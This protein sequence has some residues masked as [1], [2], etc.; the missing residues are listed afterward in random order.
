MSIY[1]LLACND[2]FTGERDDTIE[3]IQ[4]WHEGSES[5]L[6]LDGDP[7]DFCEPIEGL[8]RVEGR[9]FTAQCVQTWAGNWAWDLYRFADDEAAQL[10]EYTQGQG[11]E[12]T[13][14]A[15]FLYDSFNDGERL[16]EPLRAALSGDETPRRTAKQERAALSAWNAGEPIRVG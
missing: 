13:G 4:V 12:A 16:A 3:G 9:T 6:E 10:L 1:L 8:L 7:L 14:G 15:Q 5:V 11:W 2:P